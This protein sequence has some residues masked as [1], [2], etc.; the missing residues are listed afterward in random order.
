MDLT[1]EIEAAL[2]APFDPSEL[3]TRPGKGGSGSLTYINRAAVMDRLDQVV[4][5][6]NW[7]F[8][9]DVPTGDPKKVR[10]MLTVCGVTKMDAGEANAEDEPFKSA[11][12]DALKR[13]AVQFGIGRYLSRP[14]G[15]GQQPRQ[16]QQ[17]G[18]QRPRDRGEWNDRVATAASA[19]APPAP[20][21]TGGAPRR[22]IL[23]TFPAAETGEASGMVCTNGGCG[24]PLTTGQRD[25][26]MR[27]F[28]APLCPACQRLQAKPS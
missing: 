18:P 17:N 16:Q 19:S 2:A 13:C 21:I 10:G 20:A 6:A 26:S 14:A 22:D 25:V 27:A 4:G 12:S 11:V 9:Y 24:K 28:G 7:H 1:P 15:A 5:A 23:D 3:R 8:A